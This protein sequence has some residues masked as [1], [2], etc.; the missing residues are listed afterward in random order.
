[1][2]FWSLALTALAAASPGAGGP[3]A[4][5]ARVGLATRLGAREDGDGRVE[6]R[7][8]QEIRWGWR[9]HPRPPTG[10]A[11]VETFV[12]DPDTYEPTPEPTTYEPTVAPTPERGVRFS[13]PDAVELVTK[14]LLDPRGRVRSIKASDPI[15]GNL[16]YALYESRWSD[17]KMERASGHHIQDRGVLLHS[18][19]PR[20]YNFDMESSR[21]TT[22]R[23]GWNPIRMPGRRSLLHEDREEVN[24]PCYLAFEFRCPPT[25][26]GFVPN[27]SFNIIAGSG[28]H[29]EDASSGPGGAFGIILNG[30][31]VALDSRTTTLV[32]ITH[33]NDEV[34]TQHVMKNDHIGGLNVNVFSPQVEID[35][36]TEKLVVEAHSREGWN[37]IKIVISDDA[38]PRSESWILLEANSLSCTSGAT[39]KTSEAMTVNVSSTMRR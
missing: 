10:A 33:A 3:G 14:H 21:E 12:V 4:V 5:E 38:D 35:R 11:T 15:D 34:Q 17:R 25:S 28:E 20:D 24:D 30:E 18:G 23:Y 7:R 2:R 1:M 36:T 8:R 13:Y 39:N 26:S 32:D 9:D 22:H 6:R 31:D 29:Y 37:S 16:C 27:V 19:R